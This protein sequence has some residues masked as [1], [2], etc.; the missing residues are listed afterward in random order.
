MGCGKTT[1]GRILALRLR[2]PF[3]DSDEL[4]EEREGMPIYE[5]F[6]KKG[7]DYF[8]K[9]EREVILSTPDEGER[10]FSVGG[11]GFNEITIPYLKSIGP[12]FFLDLSFNEVKRRLSLGNKKRPLA[13]SKDLYGLFLKRRALYFR[14]HYKIWTESLTVDEVVESILRYL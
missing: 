6:K 8:R 5:I 2:I 1:V 13:D 12:T 4:I 10:V 11:G 7:E 14:A 9:I 3:K